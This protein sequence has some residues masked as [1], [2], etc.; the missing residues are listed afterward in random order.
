MRAQSANLID[1]N[2]YT[3]IDVLDKVYLRAFEK[4][5]QNAFDNFDLKCQVFKE[6]NCLIH[7]NIVHLEE[8]GDREYGKITEKLYM[9]AEE[10]IIPKLDLEIGR[11]KVKEK[12]RIRS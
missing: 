3:V 11:D 6:V 2:K 10:G 7:D 8:Q 12:F 9:D 4:H 5:N 1:G